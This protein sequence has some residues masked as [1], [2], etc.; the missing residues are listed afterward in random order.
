MAGLALLLAGALLLALNGIYFGYTSY[1]RN[2]VGDVAASTPLLIPTEDELWGSATTGSASPSDVPVSDAEAQGSKN[3][4]S[5]LASLYPGIRVAAQDW[6]QPRWAEPVVGTAAPPGFRPVALEELSDRRTAPPTRIRIPAIDLD[7]EVRGLE[8]LDLG[9]ARQY[10]TPKNV[11]GHIP[12][13]AN[14]GMP[15]NGWL[16]GHLESPIRGEGSIFRQLPQVYDLLRQG[17]DV[18]VIIDSADGSFLYQVRRFRTI[19]REELSLWD[20]DTPMVTLVTCWPR[21][22]YGDRILVE[23]ELV[24]VK[25]A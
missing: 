16:F 25:A 8:I 4:F 5:D 15:N 1:A 14:P 22:K 9:D 17:E 3:L 2:Q 20:S 7:A 11:V 21:F 18:Y 13:S 6:D 23:A 24:G 10:E 12:E 19:P